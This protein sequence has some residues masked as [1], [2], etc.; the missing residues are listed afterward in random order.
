MVW[1]F[2]G[3]SLVR[4]LHSLLRAW[5]QSLVKELRSSSYAMWPKRKKEN[6]IYLQDLTFLSDISIRCWLKFLL[7]QALLTNSTTLGGTQVNSAVYLMFAIICNHC[8]PFVNFWAVIGKNC[9]WR[10][11]IESSVGVREGEQKTREGFSLVVQWLRIH[12]Q[13]RGHRFD[14]CSG[15]IPC[16]SWQLSQPS[17]ACGPHETLPQREACTPQLKSSPLS[18]QLER[19]PQAAMKTWHSQ[20]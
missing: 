20:K 1:E 8:N 12:L 11:E 18:V 16:A 5:V 6:A 3:S 13:C 7:L 4:T 2:P 14:P 10:A 15:R 17:R 19:V 9:Y